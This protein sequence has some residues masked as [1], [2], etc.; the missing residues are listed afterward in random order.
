[1]A[2]DGDANRLT[3]AAAIG[4]ATH[5]AFWSPVL[6]GYNLEAGIDQVY[7]SYGAWTS[8]GHLALFD[9]T[10]D[11]MWLRLASENV[12][13]MNTYLREPDQG[14]ALR[15]YRCV[16]T[17]APGC[18]SGQVPKVVDHTRDTAAQAWIQHLL[19]ALA[20]R[21]ASRDAVSD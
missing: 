11:P 15:I 16:D 21:E 5:A 2:L 19:T 6:G 10:A 17:F 4:R 8:L 13:G 18:E 9:L 3:R 20:S 14:Y 12:Q 1:M 7:A